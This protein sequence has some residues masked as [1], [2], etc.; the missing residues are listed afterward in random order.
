[1]RARVVAGPCLAVVLILAAVGAW[2]QAGN[3]PVELAQ[4][5]HYKQLL[6]NQSVRV[7]S[8][9]LGPRES[10]QMHRHSLDYLMIQLQDT[11]TS[12]T[13]LTSPPSA[14]A[15]KQ[16]NEGE[17]WYI[18]GRTHAVRNDAPQP[19][20]Q[21]EIELLKLGPSGDYVRDRYNDVSQPKYF[22]PPRYPFG[23]YSE[24]GTFYNVYL[25][26]QGLLPGASSE[27]HEHKAAHLAVAL[28]DLEL[29]N[30]VEGKPAVTVRLRKGEVAWVESTA[31]HKLTNVGNRPAQ[32]VTVEY[33]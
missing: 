1:M 19:M 25:T 18:P 9:E 28:S 14:A 4:E 5:S 27:W 21:I 3:K 29:K 11:E 17:M 13:N 16:F 33:R 7:W 12:T 31:R 10:T 20:R 23:N 6:S 2:A 24:N 26:Q 22:P 15:P 32:F 30:E 8:L